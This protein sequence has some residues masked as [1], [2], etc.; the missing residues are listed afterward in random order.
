MISHADLEYP[1]CPLCSSNERDV[2]YAFDDYKVVRCRSCGLHYLFPRPKE[3][4]MRQAYAHGDYYESGDCGYS[5]VSYAMQ[6]R[7]L[8]A[9]FKHLMRNLQKHD[10]TGGDLLE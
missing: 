6:E 5:D 10:L 2:R 8:R 9:T 4:A 7:A 3:S 1:S